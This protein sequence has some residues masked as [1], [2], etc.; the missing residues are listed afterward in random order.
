MLNGVLLNKYFLIH[1][2][3]LIIINKQVESL[4]IFNVKKYDEDLFT[5]LFDVINKIQVGDICIE[6]LSGLSNT[7]EIKNFCIKMV[8][9]LKSLQTQNM[10]SNKVSLHFILQSCSKKLKKYFIST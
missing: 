2:Q 10:L 1:L 5:H 6:L 7:D 8:N 3:K 9:K 4:R